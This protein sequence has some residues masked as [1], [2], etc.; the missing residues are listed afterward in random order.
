[1]DS[2]HPKQWGAVLHDE[3]L[4]AAIVDRVLE[5]GTGIP[6]A[7]FP[8]PTILIKHYRES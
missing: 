6:L 5:R 4:A 1:L 2:Q 3:D 7:E 8:E